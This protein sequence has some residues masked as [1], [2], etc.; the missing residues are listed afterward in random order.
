MKPDAKGLEQR[1]IFHLRAAEGWLELG[2][3]A[4][5]ANELEAISPAE[6]A[7]PAVLAIRC[8]IY[9]KAEKWGP[10]AEIARTLAETQ[11]E[12][13]GG[14]INLAYATRRKAGGGIPQAKTIL[15]TAEP[16]FPGD[17]LFPFNL[18]CY[19]SQ[20]GEF[21]EAER[22]L[23]KALAINQVIVMKMALNDSDLKPLLDKLGG[24]FSLGK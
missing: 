12:E 3:A 4:S 20:L 10:A 16:R 5:A 1:D 14:W 18:A 13:P 21:D 23:Q 19:C 8:A 2:D 11:P 17:F 22:W 15:L 6:K 24:K 7:H 9:L